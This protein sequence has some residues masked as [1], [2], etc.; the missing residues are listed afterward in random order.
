MCKFCDLETL[1]AES[2][3]SFFEGA[4]SHG[5]RSMVCKHCSTTF[6]TH[7]AQLAPA[8]LAAVP[9]QHQR[10]AGEQEMVLLPA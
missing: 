6:F 2:F 10:V 5:Y 4:A 1:E 9:P 8:R 7:S 3:D